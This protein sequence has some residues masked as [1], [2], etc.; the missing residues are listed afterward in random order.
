[1]NHKSNKFIPLKIN[2]FNNKIQL[3]KTDNQ[4]FIKYNLKMENFQRISKLKI[5]NRL[6]H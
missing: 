6:K 1:M 4:L 5:K 3:I 2:L